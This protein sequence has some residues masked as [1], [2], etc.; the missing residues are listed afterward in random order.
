MTRSGP[1]VLWDKF[2]ALRH[3]MLE[4]MGTLTC[5]PDEDV[6][7]KC[8]REW[9]Y[10]KRVVVEEGLKMD[11]GDARGCLYR[12]FD[13]PRWRAYVKARNYRW[14]R[15][16]KGKANV[17]ARNKAYYATK[18]KAKRSDPA[19]KARINLMQPARRKAAKE[20]K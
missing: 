9:N 15:T 1:E 5:P 19:E 20:T 2:L 16:V 18:L 10:Y 8:F 12:M 7:K 3:H 17:S 14:R 11:P 4:L 13:D 6:W